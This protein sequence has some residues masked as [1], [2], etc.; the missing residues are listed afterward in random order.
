[1]TAELDS[2]GLAERLA[3]AILLQQRV[4]AARSVAEIRL[5]VVNDTAMLVGYRTALLFNPDGGCVAVS[6]LPTPN[7]EAPFTISAERLARW[8][9][10]RVPQGGAVDADS[11]PEALRHESEAHLAPDRLWTPIMS[12]GGRVEAWLLLAREG[13]W[14]DPE[15]QLLK[16]WFDVVGLTLGAPRRG[17]RP[18]AWRWLKRAAILTATA[19]LVAAMFVP[20]PM[21]ILA[22][23]EVIARDPD[24][25]RAPISGVVE[26]APVAP[27]AAVRAG[28]VVLRLDPRE[29]NTRLDVARQAL[30]IAQA[31]LR[32]TQQ[33]AI[34]NREA[35]SL[36]PILRARI[37]QR[38][39]EVQLVESQLARVVVA[40]GLDGVVLLPD[41]ASLRGRPVRQGERLFMIADP[42]SVELELWI[43]APDMI[44]IGPG[45][46]VTLF[47]TVAPDQSTSATLRLLSHQATA[48]PDGPMAFRGVATFDGPVPRIGLR[49]VARIE[50]P[51]APIGYYLFRRPIAAIRQ[52]F[53]L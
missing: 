36:L 44:D 22:P 31:E 9:I 41:P 43:A 6:G 46:A 32:Q 24:V 21:T 47:L 8:L 28:D 37:E 53:G 39:A 51:P 5:L 16:P 26:E 34:L 15:R 4:I 42:Q 30:E 27:N 7:R 38:R 17:P 35:Q 45:A 1:M 20:T 49:G 2:L 13:A 25:I 11:L 29:L 52:Q 50:G 19:L 18:A 23:A 12:A 48:S 14:S 10:R 40:A 33:S 3:R